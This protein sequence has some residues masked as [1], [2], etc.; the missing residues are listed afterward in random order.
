MR[1]ALVDA[2]TAMVMAFVS[3]SADG[4]PAAGAG[5]AEFFGR[6]EAQPAQQKQ[7]HIIVASANTL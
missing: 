1:T 5:V 4:T 6:T 7:R 2:C 3:C